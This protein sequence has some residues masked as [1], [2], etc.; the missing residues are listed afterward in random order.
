[1]ETL[2][3]KYKTNNDNN[4]DDDNSSQIVTLTQLLFTNIYIPQAHQNCSYQNTEHIQYLFTISMSCF[5][6]S[7][8]IFTYH[9]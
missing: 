9:D 3:K 2:N 8:H 5:V 6:S 7:T 4:I 1:M